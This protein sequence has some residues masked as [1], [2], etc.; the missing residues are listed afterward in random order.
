MQRQRARVFELENRMDELLNTL[1][2]ANE[3]IGQLNREL[4]TMAA[5]RSATAGAETSSRPVDSKPAPG[6]PAASRTAE[7]AAQS[8]DA[9]DRGAKNG[10]RSEARPPDHP[11]VHGASTVVP[12]AL[13]LPGAA[14]T[15]A[16]PALRTFADRARG[17]LVPIVGSLVV[18]LGVLLL[19]LR[20]WLRAR[21]AAADE[22]PVYSGAAVEEMLAEP[23]EEDH[24][25][26]LSPDSA[27]AM[28]T[29]EVDLNIGELAGKPGAN[30]QPAESALD[31]AIE[32]ALHDERE[33]TARVSPLANWSARLLTARRGAASSRQRGSR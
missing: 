19:A 4:D 16:D 1:K 14:A 6:T 29:T 21:V 24:W 10:G 20:W 3:R 7:A 28:V 17:R 30:D 12:P 27:D 31:D 22:G 2:Q 13:V 11:P 5:R 23:K 26:P 32:S 18:L 33:E 15:E 8:A 25:Q 9:T